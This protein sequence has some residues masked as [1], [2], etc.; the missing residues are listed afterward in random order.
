MSGS[1]GI[2]RIKGDTSDLDKKLEGSAEKMRKIGEHGE[3]AGRHARTFGE[4]WEHANGTLTRTLAHS[5]ALTHL[6]GKAAGSMK[7]IAD[8]SAK[9]SAAIGGAAIDR[10]VAAK[11][12]GL[13]SDQAAGAVG[14]SGAANTEDRNKFFSSLA[15]MKS[16][17]GRGK[18]TPDQAFRLQSAF[19]SGLYSESEL[20]DIASRGAFEEIDVGGRLAGLGEE[21]G[22]EYDTKV[23][24]QDA[25][26]RKETAEAG[27]SAAGRRTRR[28]D[29]EISAWAAAH[30]YLDKG[31]TALGELPFGLGEMFTG[32]NTSMSRMA[33]SNEEIRDH[34]ATEASKPT[35][36][37]GAE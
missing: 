20:K 23:S 16:G 33:N 18:L 32:I 24:I 12:L 14:G 27:R 29:A 21:A 7:E 34:A 15:D 31:R 35:L 2:V 22:A 11:R 1:E 17:R 8:E 36:A 37:P 4:Q 26:S 6:L 13:T 10:D 9:T 5:L 30:P 19:N 28:G 25:A 3:R